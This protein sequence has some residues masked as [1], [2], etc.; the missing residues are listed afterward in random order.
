MPDQMP[1]FTEYA[2]LRRVAIC[3][4]RFFKLGEPINAIQAREVQRGVPISAE[5]ASAEHA[6][7]A[8]ALQ[9]SGAE[10]VIIP[11]DPRFSYQINARDAGI[12]STKGL[13]LANFRLAA[14][15]GEEACAR[16]ALTQAGV[17]ILG[18]VAQSSFEGGDFVAL[19]GTLAAVG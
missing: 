19:S 12:A 4:P 7:L 17:E 15:Q 11:P 3:P 8:T 13:L 9:E 10:L 1:L 16:A 18:Q 14:R 6:A 2:Q 5:R